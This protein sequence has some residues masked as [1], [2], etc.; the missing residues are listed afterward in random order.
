MRT[1]VDRVLLALLLSTP[2]VACG[3]GFDP[4]SEITTLRPLAIRKDKPFA[5][6]GETVQLELLYHDGTRDPLDPSDT[7]P[8]TVL[9]WT[10][11][12][13]PPANAYYGCFAQLAEEEPPDG[14]SPPNPSFHIGPTASFQVKPDILDGLEPVE[15]GAPIEGSSFV[16]AAICAGT[17][18]LEAPRQQGALPFVCRDADGRRLGPDSFAVSYATIKTIAQTMEDGRPFENQNPVLEPAFEIAGETVPACLNEECQSAEFPP[19]DCEE[20][21]ERC[22][23]ACEDDGEPECPEIDIR[24]LVDPVSA[25]RDDVARVFYGRDLEEQMWINYYVDRGSVRG[26]GVRLLNDATTGWNDDYGTEFY[27]PKEEG[28]V[29]IWAVVHDDRGGVSWARTQIYVRAPER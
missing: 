6:P 7:R 28:P 19:I 18:D 27:A 29:N 24:P 11:C 17:L 15:E 1:A 8:V 2:L 25:E 13:N 12:T 23:E 4:P 5:Q 20:T 21:P 14:E 3:E 26:D 9:W 22:V 16:F 10:G